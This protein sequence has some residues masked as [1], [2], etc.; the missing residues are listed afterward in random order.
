M[1]VLRTLVAIV[2]GVPLFLV[3]GWPHS[4][5]VTF[6]LAC[7]IFAI[8]HGVEALVMQAQSSR[9]ETEPTIDP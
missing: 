1:P 6:L 7:G 4:V 9:E 3:V 5:F 2:V 8:A